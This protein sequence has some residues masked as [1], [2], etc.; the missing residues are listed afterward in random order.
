MPIMDRDLEI[1][2]IVLSLVDSRTIQSRLSKALAAAQSALATDF[3]KPAASVA[4]SLDVF[5]S[6]LP[7]ELRSCRLSVLRA[8]TVHQI[9]SHPNASQYVLSL[10]G[11][12]TIRVKSDDEWVA[13]AL[14]SDPEDSLFGRWHTVPANTW[15]QPT[16]GDHDWT[17]VAF[18]TVPANELRDEYGYV[19]GCRDNK[20]MDRT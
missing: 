19:D 3:S 5:G 17:V 13:S 12:G 9:E 10:D 4:L 18:H 1:G 8:G 14:S 6:Q 16:P 7:V 20:S 15:H 11:E 2:R